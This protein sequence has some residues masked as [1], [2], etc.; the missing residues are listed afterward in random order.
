[1]KKNSKPKKSMIK[2]S[3]S[4]H[5]EVFPKMA[6]LNGSMLNNGRQITANTSVDTAQTFFYSPE[7]TPESWLLPK[8]RIE[9]LKWVRIFFNLDPYIHE[10]INMHAQYPF[11][12][13]TLD[14]SDDKALKVFNKSMF[15][16]GI[17]WYDLI[18]QASLSY[19]KFGEAIMWGNWDAELKRWDNF[20][21]LDP[22]IVEIRQDPFSKGMEVELIPTQEIKRMIRDSILKDRNDIPEVVIK[23][24]QESRRIP[25]DAKGQP[26]NI[27]GAEYEPPKVFT[28]MRKTDPG[29]TRGTSRIQSL[30]KDLIY[31]DKIRLAQI[32]IADRHHLPIEIWTVGHLTGSPDSTFEL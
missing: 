29:A 28:F 31:K 26:G 30:F 25:L 18:L 22:D 7:L 6:T 24:V 1:M 13:F 15:H 2:A 32:A 21:C 20:T 10:I 17:D 23:A 8:S 12:T 5:P 14:C 11:S 19:N 4:N 9:V 3:T 27:Y 16:G